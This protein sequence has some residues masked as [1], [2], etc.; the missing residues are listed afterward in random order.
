MLFCIFGSYISGRIN[1]P[2]FL[3]TAMSCLI[4]Y[5]FG[6][7]FFNSDWPHKNMNVAIP[8]VI[9]AILSVVIVYIRPEVALNRNNYPVYLPVLSMAFVVSLYY[10]IKQ[11]IAFLPDTLVKS[12]SLFGKDSLLILGFHR[13]LFIILEFIFPLIGLTGLLACGIKFLLAFPFIYAVK[14]PVE[15]HLPFIIG[16]TK[17]LK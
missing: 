9:I 3:D 11:I 8:W 17:K 13:F 6:Y 15:K 16:K 7:E 5:H 4:Y 1:I 10:I 14:I 2:F 12:L